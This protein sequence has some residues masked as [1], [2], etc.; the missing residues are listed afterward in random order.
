MGFKVSDGVTNACMESPW[1]NGTKRFWYIWLAFCCV[2]MLHDLA[3]A[4]HT[5]LLVSSS[6]LLL[7]FSPLRTPATGRDM[8]VVI[9]LVTSSSHTLPALQLSGATFNPFLST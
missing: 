4:R 6:P 2:V 9:P 7:L 3:L 5:L 8:V 1:N